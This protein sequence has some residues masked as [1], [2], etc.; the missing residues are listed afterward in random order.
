MV[1][2][3]TDNAFRWSIYNICGVVH[4]SLRSLNRA[5]VHVMR[6]DA[7]LVYIYSRAFIV[8]TIYAS[9]AASQ[10]VSQS[11][12]QAGDQALIS[13]VAERA[14]LAKNFCF[15]NSLTPTA[16]KLIWNGPAC[17][18]CL[19]ETANNR[20]YKSVCVHLSQPCIAY[21]TGL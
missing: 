3:A 13:R 11:A 10:P 20:D 1:A 4:G 5:L 21:Y 8:Y 7:M 17:S 12:G 19:S 2:T 15:S 6:C 9:R 18:G 16:N 14:L